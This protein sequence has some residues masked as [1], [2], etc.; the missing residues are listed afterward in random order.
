MENVNAGRVAVSSTD[1]LGFFIE[2]MAEA[3]EVD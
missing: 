3:T 2:F 1:W